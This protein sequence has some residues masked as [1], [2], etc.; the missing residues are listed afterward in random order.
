MVSRHARWIVVFGHTGSAADL[1]LRG[2]GHRRVVRCNHV[3]SPGSRRAGGVR[4]DGIS[5]GGVR[6]TG[7]VLLRQTWL[8]LLLLSQARLLLLQRRCERLRHVVLRND[9]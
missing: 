2:L 1:C 5:L 8:L 4:R 9:I 7:L 6:H 3:I